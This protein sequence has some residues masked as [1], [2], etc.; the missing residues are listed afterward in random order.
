MLVTLMF[1]VV[2]MKSRTFPSFSYSA[3]EQGCRS[4]EGAQPGREPKVASGNIPYHG[5]FAQ[6]RNG[7]W[8]G[9]QGVFFA[10]LVSMSLNP[11]LSGSMNFSGN[12]AKFMIQGSTTA[13]RGLTA[14]RSLGVRKIV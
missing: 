7:R 13:A 5:H 1:L 4:W 2:A 8:P 12:F 9:G 6:L 11:L 3:D 10:L 14:N